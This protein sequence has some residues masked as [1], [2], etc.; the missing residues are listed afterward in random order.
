MISS[1][2]G[3]AGPSRQAAASR[4]PRGAAHCPARF[5]AA[6]ARRAARGAAVRAASGNG[7]SD[8]L[9][10]VVVGAGISGLVTA[11]ALA[12]KHAGDVGSF[13]V[14]EARE[15]VGGNITSMAGDG[16]VWEEGPNSFQPNDAM[17]MAAVR[18]RSLCVVLGM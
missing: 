3:M 11:Q 17:L 12:T 4:L 1:H 6:A 14:T 8:V 13:L 15:R 2:A 5:A 7:A 16:Y 10:T 9:D 18:R